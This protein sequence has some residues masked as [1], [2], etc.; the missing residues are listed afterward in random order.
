MRSNEEKK[1]VNNCMGG[2][3]NSQKNIMK[4]ATGDEKLSFVARGLKEAK[5]KEIKILVNC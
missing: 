2:R 5:N 1:V 4:I 3:R